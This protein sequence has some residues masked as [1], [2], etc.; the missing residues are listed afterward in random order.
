VLETLGQDYVRMAH[1]KGL[2]R[3]RIRLVHVLRNSLVPVLSAAGPLLGALITTL[4]VVEVVFG[5]PG[6]ARHYVSATNA[7]DYP[8]LMGMT[9]AITMFIIVANLVV[10]LVLAALDPRLREHRAVG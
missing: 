6:L 2:R 9:V 10:D 8:L 1:A 4:F 7:R 5:I 3:D